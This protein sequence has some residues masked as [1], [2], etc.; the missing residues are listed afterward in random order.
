M[1][2]TAYLV[3]YCER[4][5]HLNCDVLSPLFFAPQSDDYFCVSVCNYDYV[6]QCCLDKNIG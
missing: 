3:G 1:A 2:D 4:Q 6:C 5:H